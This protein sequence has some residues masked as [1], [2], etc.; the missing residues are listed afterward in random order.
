MIVTDANV[1]MALCVPGPNTNAVEDLKRADPDWIAPDLWRAEVLNAL[2]TQ[3]RTARMSL[4]E[5]ASAFGIAERAVRT[6]SAA[7]DAGEL[8]RS[9]AQTGCS[10]YDTHYILLAENLDVKLITYDQQVL[11]KCSARAMTPDQFLAAA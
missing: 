3:V 5:A 2:C 10:G 6:Y 4:T 8:L 7:L 1:I 11:N 9:A